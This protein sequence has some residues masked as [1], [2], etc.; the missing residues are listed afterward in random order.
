MLH[1]RFDGSLLEDDPM[2]A[3]EKNALLKG[4]MALVGVE[5]A[6]AVAAKPKGKRK[7]NPEALAKWRESQKATAPA[8]AK[9]TKAAPAKADKPKVAKEEFAGG[10]AMGA[11]QKDKKGRTWVPVWVNGEYGGSMRADLARALFVAIRSEAAKDMLAHVQL[12]A[13]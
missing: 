7:G 13:E 6:P 10:I 3:A 12:Q 9:A 11:G 1:G 5:D 2:T 4:L 8:K